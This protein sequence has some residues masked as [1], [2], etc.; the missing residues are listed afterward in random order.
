MSEM[1]LLEKKCSFLEDKTGQEK[2]FLKSFFF[3][4]MKKKSNIKFLCSNQKKFL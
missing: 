1:I 3:Y 4:F 2:E